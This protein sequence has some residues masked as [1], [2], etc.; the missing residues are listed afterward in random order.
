MTLTGDT[1]ED[2]EASPETFWKN[3]LKTE[4]SDVVNEKAPEPHYKP[5]ET[6]ITIST[7][8]PKQSF[9]KRFGTLSIDWN[10]VENKLR[11]WSHLGSSLHVEISFI[12][13]EIQLDTTNKLAARDKLIA[14]Q[15]ASGVRPVWKEVYELFECSNAVCPNRGFS[16]W[17]DPSNKRHVKLDSDTMDKLIDYAEEGNTLEKHDDDGGCGES[18]ANARN[19]TRRSGQARLA[20]PMPVDEAPK[21]YCDWLCN[22]V[23]NKTWKDA[24]QL[25]CRVTLEKGY[26]LGR[27]YEAQAVDAKMLAT[28][29]VLPGIAIQFVSRIGD[30]LDDICPE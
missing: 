14:Q 16:C 3:T 15:Q 18:S 4:L 27:M 6:R 21:S 23:T 22:Q 5:E 17:R 2:I 19:A 28:S 29:G 24:Y 7:K 13:K 20:F 9:Q 8:R 30:W 11:S 25:A 10:I 1:V 12:Y 26:H